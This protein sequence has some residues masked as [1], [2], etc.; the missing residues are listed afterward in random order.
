L[1]DLLT[2]TRRRIEAEQGYFGAEAVRV[3][4]VNPVA[5]LR[6]MNLLEECGGRICGTDYLFSHALDPIPEDVEPMEALARMALA[7]PMVGRAGDRADRIIRDIRAFGAQ[8]LVLSRIPGASHCAH[9]GAVIGDKVRTALG[10]PVCE[11]EVPPVSDP[12]R[13]TIRTRI[14]ALIETVRGRRED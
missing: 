13:P 1:D 6:A 11:I 3:F 14:E 4:W 9:E 8:A 10:I 12:V 5:D 7:D 2:E